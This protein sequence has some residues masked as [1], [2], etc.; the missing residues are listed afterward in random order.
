MKW[1]N[2]LSAYL[3]ENLLD[4]HVVDDDTVS[5]RTLSEATVSIPQALHAHTAG[6]LNSTIRNQ[7]HLLE[8]AR[9]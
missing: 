9:V 2:F 8:I 5:P 4:D 6:E 7:F 1:M 3:Y